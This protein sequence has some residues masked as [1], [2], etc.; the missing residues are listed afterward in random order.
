MRIF[1]ARR[2]VTGSLAVVLII[3]TG[4]W[5]AMNTYAHVGGCRTDPIIKM[6]NGKQLELTAT[7]TDDA[8]NV[9]KVI[10][11][12]HIPAGVQVTSEIFTGNT[13]AGKESITVLADGANNAY[14][15]GFVASDKNSVSVTDNATLR[16]TGT[17]T[18]TASQSV[19]GVTNQNL[20]VSFAG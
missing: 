14:T 6:S 19:S 13:F 10:Y 17:G 15:A 20:R 7:I 8:T 9:S 18:A 3:G 5:Y 4:S 2:A 11:T 16:H 1:A 12:L